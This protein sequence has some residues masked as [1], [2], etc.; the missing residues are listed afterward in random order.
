MSAIATWWGD[1]LGQFWLIRNE[2]Q[3]FVELKFEFFSF[4]TSMSLRY[5]GNKLYK[6]GPNTVIALSWRNCA[7]FH[8]LRY[9]I[10]HCVPYLGCFL[11]FILCS[12]VPSIFGTIWCVIFQIYKIIHHSRHLWREYNFSSCSLSQE[13]KCCTSV[14]LHVNVHWIASIACMSFSLYGFQSWQQYS[15]RGM[16]RDVKSISMR[17]RFR[18]W[19]TLNTHPI[20]SL[21]FLTIFL[22]WRVKVAVLL[23]IMPRSPICSLLSIFE[24]SY[25]L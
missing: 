24:S 21:A 14:I 7:G 5:F 15:S 11:V 6:R 9:W 20:L 17:E 23:I 16:T 8:F 25:D 1:I 10:M 12:I 18:N 3:K 13:F 2:L 19:N 4:Y 22:I